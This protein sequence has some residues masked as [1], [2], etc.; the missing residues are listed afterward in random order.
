MNFYFYFKSIKIKLKL[1]LLLFQIFTNG[2]FVS[3][4]DQNEVDPRQVDP[5]D[6]PVETA[7]AETAP[8]ETAQAA[9]E[10][11]SA[12]PTAPGDLNGA[13]TTDK[14]GLRCVN[15]VMQV[16]RFFEGAFVLIRV[17]EYNF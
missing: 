9:A 12:E 17:T 2:Y 1:N 14:N 8:A 13:E 6:A 3:L 4:L 16:K 5:E 10:T 15:K 11:T 7:P